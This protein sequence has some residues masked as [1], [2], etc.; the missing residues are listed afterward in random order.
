VAA[1]IGDPPAN[2]SPWGRSRPVFAERALARS[3]LV[4]LALGAGVTDLL[5]L[6]PEMRVSAVAERGRSG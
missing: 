5:Q 6:A 1:E 4:W 3:M 2:A